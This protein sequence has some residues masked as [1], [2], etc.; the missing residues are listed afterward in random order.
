M[1]IQVM[2]KWHYDE[3]MAIE[4]ACHIKRMTRFDLTCAMFGPGWEAIVALDGKT[5]V[6]F[7]IY[8]HAG[9]N[10]A[11]GRIAVKED[12]RRQGVGTA[13]VTHA[14]KGITKPGARIMLFVHEKSMDAQCFFRALGFR[15]VKV[16]RKYYEETGEDAYRMELLASKW[17]ARRKEEARQ[18]NDAA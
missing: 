13:L 11:L 9:R 15:A 10:I 2:A 4:A 16:E 18:P 7:A 1:R 3:A 14:F 17:R 6:G 12:H 8:M 5:V